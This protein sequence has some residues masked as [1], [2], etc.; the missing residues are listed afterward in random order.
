MQ[1]HSDDWN[2]KWFPLPFHHPFS[3]S[4]LRLI[5]SPSPVAPH[6]TQVIL[7]CQG[8]STIH[9]ELEEANLTQTGRMMARQTGAWLRGIPI[10]AIYASP[11]KRAQQT[12]KELLVGM[13]ADWHHLNPIHLHWHLQETDVSEGQGA[14]SIAA[15]TSLSTQFTPVLELYDRAQRFWQDI[16]PRHSGQ[17]VLV[18][19][20]PST[21]QALIN[22]A[23]GLPNYHHQQF[24]QCQGSIS[25]LNFT[26]QT[27][28]GTKLHTLNATHHLGKG[29]PELK[30][31]N[32]G[33]RLLL[34]PVPITPN[35]L[36]LQE[37]LKEVEI[38]FSLSAD[39]VAPDL[40]SAIL[41]NHPRTVHLQVA[42]EDFAQVWQ[43]SI[44]Q[45]KADIDHLITG[46]IVASLP[47]VQA[48]LQQAIEGEQHLRPQLAIQAGHLSVIH[49]PALSHFPILQA[50]NLGFDHRTLA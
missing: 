28:S 5:P 25:M 45:R 36:W 1:W 10:N 31:G 34:L 6:P 16:L 39:E 23:L 50:I 48:L 9:T 7:V 37:L 2:S 15:P 21:N 30:Q 8:H 3:P 11:F 26:D 40:V 44:K 42:R 4:R 32:Q 20:H 13:E 24:Q 19:S 46:L 27:L 33:L 35:Q 49:Y 18:V 47:M 38:N 14:S 12:V 17:T 43:R 22:T 41:V 29:L